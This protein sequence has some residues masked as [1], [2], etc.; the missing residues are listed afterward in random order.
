M[1]DVASAYLAAAERGRSGATY[2]VSSGTPVTMRRLL[3]GLIEAFGLD[4]GIQTD[5]ERVRSID[6]PVFVGDS[7]LLRRDT[8]WEPSYTLP[9]TLAA[10]AESARRRVT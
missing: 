7:S 4:V 5:P 10:L 1:R 2:N 9:E 6:Q 3:T 8:G